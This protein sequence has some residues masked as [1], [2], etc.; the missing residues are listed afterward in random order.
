MNTPIEQKYDVTIIDRMDVLILYNL[1][2][3]K[4]ILN[5]IDY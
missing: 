1:I 5:H 2:Y 3:K 4:D